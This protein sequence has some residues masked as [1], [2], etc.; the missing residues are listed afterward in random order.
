MLTLLLAA[1]AVASPLELTAEQKTI[2]RALSLRDG[3]PPCE[4]VE[5]LSKTPVDDLKF[6]VAHVT[7]PPWVGMRAAACLIARHPTEI[8]AELDTWVTDPNLVG[9]GILTLNRID[10]LPVDIGTMV[11]ALALD[12]G[13]ERIGAKKRLARSERPEILKLVTP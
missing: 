9:L 10:A 6:M 12:N 13:P 2:H 5:S 7:A 1:T 11:A 8:A 3:A 4:Q